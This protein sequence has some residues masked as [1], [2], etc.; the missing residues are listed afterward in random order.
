M[1]DPHASTSAS[2]AY[3]DDCNPTFIARQ[4]QRTDIYKDN[5]LSTLYHP[6]LFHGSASFLAGLLFLPKANLKLATVNNRASD[7]NN[8]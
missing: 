4:A 7:M 3:K 1:V 5:R 6:M 8:Q 2:I